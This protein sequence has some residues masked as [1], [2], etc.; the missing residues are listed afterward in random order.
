MTL[1]VDSTSNRNEYH[2]YLLV[3]KG[4]GFVGMTNRISRHS[5]SLI[6][7]KPYRSI[8]G[9]NGTTFHTLVP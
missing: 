9:C 1:W 8:Q 2:G 5:G 4:S 7:L 3:G 6:H